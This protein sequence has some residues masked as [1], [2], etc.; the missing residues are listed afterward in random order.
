MDKEEKNISGFDREIYSDEFERHEREVSSVPAEDPAAG[1][2]EGDDEKSGDPAILDSLVYHLTELRARILRCV[3]AVLFVF[4]FT[5]Y[6]SDSI[7]KYTS[8]SVKE[9]LKGEKLVFISPAEAFFVSLK[10]ALFAAVL[11]VLPYILH[12]FWKFVY[13]AL[14]EKEKMFFNAILITSAASFYAG[15]LFSVYLAIP[16][17]IGFLVG[18]SSEMFRPMI[19]VS[20][21]YD[22]LIGMS[23]VFGIVFELPVALLFMNLLGFVKVSWLVG[24]R[25]YAVLVIFIIGGIFSPPDVFSQF[26]V[27]VPMIVLYEL[28]IV[29]IR[30]FGK[31]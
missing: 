31:K 19:S 21:Y 11:I 15:L 18:Y 3:G 9:I 6:Y 8:V 30:V 25:K 2:P 20:A 27:S 28:G 5:A 7:M 12:Q 1:E 23:L 17:G 22:F 26:L 29:M 24:N 4:L 16:V 13:V 10:V 14:E